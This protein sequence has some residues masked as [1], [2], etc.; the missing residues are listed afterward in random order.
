M[1]P[2]HS[3]FWREGF[4]SQS[5]EAIAGWYRDCVAAQIQFGGPGI[6]TH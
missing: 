6:Q 3:W 4:V 2:M 5:P 1:P